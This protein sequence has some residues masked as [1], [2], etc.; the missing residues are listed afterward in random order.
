MTKVVKVNYNR[1]EHIILGGIK[2]IDPHF[3]KDPKVEKARMRI[4]KNIQKDFDERMEKGF[5]GYEDYTAEEQA[6]LSRILMYHELGKHFGYPKCC[7]ADFIKNIPKRLDKVKIEKRAFHGTGFVPC[8]D[9]NKVVQQAGPEAYIEIII[10]RNR[11]CPDRFPQHANKVDEVS[12]A[13][14]NKY[15]GIT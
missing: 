15:K 5:F 4:A 12:R 14:M 11:K 3:D 8:P 13:I 6:A 10:N 1:V 9:C 2:A 7:I